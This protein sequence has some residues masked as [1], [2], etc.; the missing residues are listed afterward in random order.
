MNTKLFVF[1]AF[2]LSLAFTSCDSNDPLDPKSKSSSV[3]VIAESVIGKSSSEARTI[4]LNKGY[5]LDIGESHYQT[6]YYPDI[7]TIDEMVSQEKPFIRL[8]IDHDASIVDDVSA[9]QVFKSIKEALTGFSKW[10]NYLSKQHD[11]IAIWYSVINCFDENNNC[12]GHAFLEGERSDEYRQE[13][14]PKDKH[15]G[16][17][18]DYEKM[19]VELKSSKNNYQIREWFFDIDDENNGTEIK[20][21]YST[22]GIPFSQYPPGHSQ[23]ATSSSKPNHT[24]KFYMTTG[25]WDKD[26]NSLIDALQHYIQ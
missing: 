24:A 13:Y 14:L 21:E 26:V 23:S 6:F 18:A 22:K 3:P 8:I 11:T 2:V 20:C 4:I 1:A 16:N 9:Y 5:V 25:K 15:L 10:S 17:R 19:L 7:P 12:E